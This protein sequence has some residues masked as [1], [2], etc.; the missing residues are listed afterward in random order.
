MRKH[1]NALEH[2]SVLYNI[3]L[4]IALLCGQRPDGRSPGASLEDVEDEEP[5][6]EIRRTGPLL[7][8]LLASA[9]YA[10]AVLYCNAVPLSTR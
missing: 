4:Y 5:R 1:C 9:P 6:P 2:H 10:C 8:S 7:H 3:V